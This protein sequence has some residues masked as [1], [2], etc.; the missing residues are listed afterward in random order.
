MAQRTATVQ[1]LVVGAIGLG[2]VVLL[3]SSAKA[4][5]AP[6]PTPALVPPPAH[7]PTRE[8]LLAKREAERKAREERRE[9]IIK[10]RGKGGEDR[11]LYG[12]TRPPRGTKAKNL[13]DNYRKCVLEGKKA[14]AA[15]TVGSIVKSVEDAMRQGHTASTSLGLMP[16]FEPEHN[17]REVCKQLCLLEDHLNQREKR[18]DDCIRKHFLTI[19][20]LLEEGIGLDKT[21]EFKAA[22]EKGLAL[23]MESQRS[24]SAGEPEAQI[25]QRLRVLRKAWSER[26]F[27]ASL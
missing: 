3:A 10:E 14:A 6:A 24:W 11:R 23:V 13:W 12:C 4:K 20:A 27:T 26:C 25:A 22:L 9:R 18:C 1:P 16:V 15:K 5:T 2:L 17:M 7:A 21:G 19:E 8:E